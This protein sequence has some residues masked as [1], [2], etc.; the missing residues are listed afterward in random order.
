MVKDS[1][2]G[3]ARMTFW[4]VPAS[5]KPRAF[6]EHPARALLA[7][8]SA[9]SDCMPVLPSEIDAVV[10]PLVAFDDAGMRLGYGGGNYDRFLVQLKPEA[11]VCGVAFAEQ[12]AARI[13]TEPHDKPLPRIVVA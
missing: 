3:D 7:G 1:P 12:R 8:D 13:P 9:L 5:P 2:E 4:D 11:L 10:A 6:F